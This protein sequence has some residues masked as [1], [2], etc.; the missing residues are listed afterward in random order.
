MVVRPASAIS[1]STRPASSMAGTHVGGISDL[2][3]SKT[4]ASSFHD[5]SEVKQFKPVRDI[6]NLSPE[7]EGTLAEIKLKMEDEYER[8]KQDIEEI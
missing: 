4:L 6:L 3:F 7:E 5:D 2:G 1:S 8:I